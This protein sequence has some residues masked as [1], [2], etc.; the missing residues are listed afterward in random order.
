MPSP[1]SVSPDLYREL[2]TTFFSSSSSTPHLATDTMAPPVDTAQEESG[3][4]APVQHT[5]YSGYNPQVE[6]I[7][8]AVAAS[9]AEALIPKKE[10]FSRYWPAVTFSM[11]LSVALVMEGMDVGLINNF[12]AHP[13]YLK[14][15]GWPDKDGTQHISTKWQGA[16]GAGNNCGSILGLLLNGWLQARFGSRRVYMVCHSPPSLTQKTQS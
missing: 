7:E 16:I 8:A 12:F 5:E 15:F 6:L 1:F 14:K 9:D 3:R 4:K 11:L 10:L 2:S 13:A